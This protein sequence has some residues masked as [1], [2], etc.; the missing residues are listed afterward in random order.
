M[1]WHLALERLLIRIFCLVCFVY[2]KWTF[3]QQS[4]WWMK[5]LLFS[6]W[7][8]K[9]C[10]SFR[11]FAFLT[12]D[13]QQRIKR[14]LNLLWQYPWKL[15]AVERQRGMEHTSDYGIFCCRSMEGHLPIIFVGLKLSLVCTI[16]PSGF[17]S[18]PLNNS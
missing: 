1:Y 7:V 8:H 14:F 18:L 10:V 16:T 12:K 5:D 4:I 2:T 15:R 9:F 6:L 17:K 13:K 11:A 3:A